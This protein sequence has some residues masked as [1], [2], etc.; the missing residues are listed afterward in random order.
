MKTVIAEPTPVESFTGSHRDIFSKT[1]ALKVIT[2]QTPRVFYRFQVV[3]T[4]NTRG[5]F[6]G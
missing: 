4:W 6:V 3:S 5:V 1:T 2:L